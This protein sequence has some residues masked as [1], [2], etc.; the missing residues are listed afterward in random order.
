MD[1]KI[2][3]FLRFMLAIALFFGASAQALAGSQSVVAQP[4]LG[5]DD[6]LAVQ[7]NVQSHVTTLYS[8]I[9]DCP[10][11]PREVT[12]FNPGDE[13]AAWNY[14]Q[15]CSAGDKYQWVWV[16]PDGQTSEG[17]VN[18]VRS[19]G[20]WCFASYW[21]NGIPNKP[22]TWKVRFYYNQALKYT[23]IFTVL[24]G[25][26]DWNSV[27]NELFSGKKQSN[28]ELLRQFRD[29]VLLESDLGQ[30]YVY[31]L[32]DRSH[33][34]A[35]I[36]LLNPEI[37]AQARSVLNNLAPEVHYVLQGEAGFLS[38]ALLEELNTLL[39]AVHAEAGP[40]LQLLIKDVQEDL[41]KNNVLGQFGMQKTFN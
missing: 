27:Y 34:V 35:L 30:E 36:L 14:T 1:Q 41:K 7:S 3:F 2:R 31:R 18:S 8:H 26:S 23:D 40:K 10:E 11:V 24:S 38:Q 19:S 33:E 28:L 15:N 6:A 17:S 12:Q 20:N 13:V 25:S 4:C 32:Y 22:G 37:L 21:G 9:T 39:D 16:Y 29:D 5:C